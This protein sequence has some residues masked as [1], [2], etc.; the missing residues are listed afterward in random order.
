MDNKCCS[1]TFELLECRDEES[2]S[3][4]RLNCV[5]SSSDELIPND[6]LATVSSS[7]IGPQPGGLG[8]KGGRRAARSAAEGS[9]GGQDRNGSVHERQHNDYIMRSMIIFE[10]I[11]G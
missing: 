3:P 11:C 10:I 8:Q 4:Q 2:L 1:V 9:G 5:H 7:P 6:R